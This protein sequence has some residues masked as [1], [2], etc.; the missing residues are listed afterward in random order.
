MNVGRD[1]AGLLG[2]HLLGRLDQ[3]SHRRILQISLSEQGRTLLVEAHRGVSAVESRMTAGLSE[4]EDRELVRLL[5][6]CASALTTGSLRSG[7]G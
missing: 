4:R 7:R 5:D 6:A 1:V 3:H 2:H